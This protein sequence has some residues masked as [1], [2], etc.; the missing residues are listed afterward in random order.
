[1]LLKE[2]KYG[3]SGF[4]NYSHKLFLFCFNSKPELDLDKHY[5]NTYIH[6]KKRPVSYHIVTVLAER[7]ISFLV[8]LRLIRIDVLV[9]QLHEKFQNIGS[10]WTSYA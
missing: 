2:H 5:I 4:D 10:Q 3:I 1:M 6:K 9:V 8:V 7:H